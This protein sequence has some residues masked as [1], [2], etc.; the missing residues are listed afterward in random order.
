MKVLSL[1]IMIVF[2]FNANA[3]FVNAPNVQNAQVKRIYQGTGTVYVQFS[4]V[5]MSACPGAGGYLTPSW[6]EANG[7]TVNEAA[8]ARMLSVLLAAK[9]AGW[10]FE[11]RYKINQ[12]GN[13]GWNSCAITGIYLN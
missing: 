5:T 8:T 6:A 13:G 9:A 2:S 1:L 10:K 7:G 4:G 3:G 12:S 11:V